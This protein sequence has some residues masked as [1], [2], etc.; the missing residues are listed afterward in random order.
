MAFGRFEVTPDEVHAYFHFRSPIIPLVQI[1]QNVRNGTAFEKFYKMGL[2]N[3]P[4]I[5]YSSPT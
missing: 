5:L 4:T 3:H 1:T 2:P